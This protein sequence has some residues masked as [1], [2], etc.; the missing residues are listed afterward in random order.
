MFASLTDSILLPVFKPEENK[1]ELYSSKSFS[2]NPLQRYILDLNT[3]YLGQEKLELELCCF[4]N[5]KGVLLVGNNFNQRGLKNELNLRLVLF[6]LNLM[7][8]DSAFSKMF[9]PENKIEIKRNDLIGYIE[10]KK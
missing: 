10:V 7:N 8:M 4:L 5:E 1:F 2:I 9:G 3:R 6:N